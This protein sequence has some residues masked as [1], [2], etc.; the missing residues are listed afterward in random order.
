M[1]KINGKLF[2]GLLL[3]AAVLAGTVFGVHLFQYER[4][5]QAL[6][7]QARR[8]E[9]QGQ[10]E[11]MARYLSRYLE[12]NPRDDGEK[13]RLATAWASDAFANAPRVRH[14]AVRLLDEVLTR[15][16]NRPE[17]RRL[18]VRTALDLGGPANLKLARAHLEKL[19]AWEKVLR[20]DA[21]AVDRERGELEG[22]WAQLLEAENKPAEAVACCRLAVRHAPEAPAHAVRLAY[23]L[24]RQKETDPGKRDQNRHEADALLDALVDRNGT[25]HHAFVARWRYRRDFDLLDFRPGEPAPGRFPLA[26]ARQDVAEA[27]KRAPEESEALLAAA[28]LE[29]M[30]GQADFEDPKLQAAQRE[31][32]MQ[33]HRDRAYE[34]LQRGLKLQEGLPAR[35][36]SDAARRKLLWQKAGLLLDDLKRADGRRPDDPA[37]PAP[38]VVHAWEA[39]AARTIDRLRRT[40]PVSPADIDYLQGRLLAHERRW[41]EAAALFEHARPLL[42]THSDLATQIN[43]NLAEC[44]DWLEE[45][46]LMLSAYQR[47]VENDADN[48]EAVLGMANADRVMRRLDAAALKYQQVIAAG[49]LPDNRWKVYARLEIDRQSQQNR[50][51]WDAV[52]K[53]L[54]Q[55]AKVTPDDVDVPLLEADMWVRRNEQARAAEVIG[56]AQE[57]WPREAKVWA[58]ATDLALNRRG[59]DLPRARHILDEAREKVGDVVI[60]R[61]AGARLLAATVKREGADKAAVLR[62]VDALA[63]RADRYSEEDRGQLLAG[64]AYVHLQADDAA[65]ARALWEKV[66]ALPRFRTDLRLRLLLFDL[67]L[68]TDNTA[69]MEKALQDVRAVERSE[70]TLV[71]YGQALRL[72]WGLRKKKEKGEPLGS[73]LA[74]ARVLLDQVLAQRPNWPAVYLARSRVHELDGNQE[75]AIKDLREAMHN[76]DNSPE[77]VREL[78]RLLLDRGRHAEAEQELSKVRQTLLDSDTDLGRLQARVALGLHRYEE[79]ARIVQGARI[80]ENNYK[81]LI[82]KGWVLAEA[83]KAA[84]AEACFRKAV[85]VAPKEPAALVALIQFMVIQKHGRPDMLKQLELSLAR[86]PAEK[87]TLTRAQCCEVMGMQE[88]ARQAYKKA[89]EERPRDMAVVRGAANFFLAVGRTQEAEPYL[90]RILNGAVDG[91]SPGDRDWARHGLALVLATGND[92]HRF[93]EALELEGVQL[94]DHGRLVREQ[95]RGETSEE[96]K[97]QA[98]VLAA[99]IGQ[100]QFRQR[101]I[102]LLENLERNKVLLPNDRYV[103]AVLY[104]ADG[105]HGKAQAIFADLVRGRPQMPQHLVRYIQSLLAHGNPEEAQKWVERLEE[106]ESFLELEPNTYASVEMRARLEEA[107]GKG[108]LAVKQLRQ[109]VGR[110]KARPEEVLLV[111]DSLRRQKKYDL[112]YAECEKMWAE[113]KCKPEVCGGASVAVLRVMGATEDQ[114]GRLEKRLQ[115]AIDANARARVKSAM[116]LLHL[117]DL[118]DLRGRYA[119]AEKLYATVLEEGNDPGN[120][121]A[122]NNRAWLLAHREGRA[123][124]ALV[125]VQKAIDG[126]GRRADLLDTRGLVYLKLG[127]SDAAL[128][129]LQEAAAEAPT[130]TRL[131]HLAKA[132][133]ETRDAAR[134]RQLLEQAQAL[135]KPSGKALPAVMHPTEQ[136]ECHRLLD[137]LKIR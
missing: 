110:P 25:D 20:A 3:A 75:Q 137:E 87:Q 14:R 13:A 4:I 79:A 93:R 83:R 99:Q 104:E 90:R 59:G 101:A 102:E 119:E 45:P 124:E 43:L 103:L 23:L 41:A 30:L 9:E 16:A 57:K 49:R 108:D 31:Q 47:V 73:D 38:E 70:G 126:I 34:H 40:P 11:R 37:A 51:D 130:P 46:S 60:L 8:A 72:L 115:E 86:L 7:W 26:Q 17:L 33:E 117:A 12:F 21:G 39:E 54:G 36:A 107:Q 67:A 121:V 28:E 84:E 52:E 58:F 91:S 32:G 19:L 95:G 116:L 118:Y 69:G 48:V 35:S 1:R 77:V 55:A 122:L 42:T 109:H 94:D 88:E 15:D 136:E 98:R 132:Y 135:V 71:R 65:G 128:A 129:D 10:V 80:D 61:L 127:Q 63:D 92:Y 27:L 44:Y 105:A 134:A 78:A 100:R 74:E 24:R 81:E 82:F 64:L 123:A 66:A 125:S 89:E 68:K 56:R 97:S 22:F 112:A 114:V 29:R 111:I 53:V 18:L 96:Q 120:V 131:F 6:L 5:A 50:P 62:E 113:Q 133:H 76:G 106:M 2:L 85:E